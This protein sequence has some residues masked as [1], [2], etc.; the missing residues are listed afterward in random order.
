VPLIKT[1][2]QIDKYIL[3]YD[4]F[5]F[6]LDSSDNPHLVY[7]MSGSIDKKF[8]LYYGY[9]KDG[10]WVVIKMLTKILEYSKVPDGSPNIKYPN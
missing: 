6:K 5:S 2:I 4:T 8:Y 3:I 7:I 1:D 10:Q 9:L